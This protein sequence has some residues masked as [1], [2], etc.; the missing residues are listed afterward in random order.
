VEEIREEMRQQDKFVDEF[1]KNNPSALEAKLRQL[2][3]EDAR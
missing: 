2:R 1:M 3:G